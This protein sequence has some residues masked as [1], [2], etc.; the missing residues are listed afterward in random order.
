MRHFRVR[1]FSGGG[2]ATAAPPLVDIEGHNLSCFEA[3]EVAALTSWYAS[4]GVDA[5]YTS[6]DTGTT[7]RILIEIVNTKVIIET[8]DRVR[9]ERE[10]LMIRLKRYEGVEKP[11]KGDTLTLRSSGGLRKYKLTGQPVGAKNHLEWNIEFSRTL[12][13]VRGSAQTKRHVN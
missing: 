6:V 13:P 11:E 4:N 7:D 12:R 2:A 5:D 9:Y 8:I 10:Y 3:S 1:H